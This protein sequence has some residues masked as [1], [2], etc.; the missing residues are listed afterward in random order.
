MEYQQLMAIIEPHDGRRDTGIELDEY[1]FVNW[2]LERW[3]DRA[4]R[5]QDPWRQER[6]QVV[7]WS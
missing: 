3:H 1:E 5:H 4:Y 2:N 6:S 7:V